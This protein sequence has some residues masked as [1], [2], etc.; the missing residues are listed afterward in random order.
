PHVPDTLSL[1]DA[2]PISLQ[3]VRYRQKPM[4]M[5]SR[6][7]P[8]LPPHHLHPLHR[9]RS[10]ML[11]SPSKP[12]PNAVRQFLSPKRALRVMKGKHVEK[13]RKSTRLNSSHVKIS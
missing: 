8:A 9:T 2:L 6:T 5:H 13:D 1:H 7:R 10:S 3:R 12:S 11:L 4:T